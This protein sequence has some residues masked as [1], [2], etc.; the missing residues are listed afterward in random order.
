MSLPQFV[1]QIAQLDS[2]VQKARTR[3]LTEV[4]KAAASS[5]T[6]WV[7]IMEAS[8]QKASGLFQSLQAQQVQ[9]TGTAV[10][11]EGKREAQVVKSMLDAV[12]EAQTL[13]LP[14]VL[15]EV[16]EWGTSQSRN[17][18]V[19]LTGSAIEESWLE[20]ATA[21]GFRKDTAGFSH[22]A[23]LAASKMVKV[24]E[25]AQQI[26]VNLT[27]AD[28]VGVVES[29]GQE[30]EHELARLQHALLLSDMAKHVVQ[31]ANILAHNALSRATSAEASATQALDRARANT[32]RITKLKLRVQA[33]QQ[34]AEAAQFQQ[35]R[36]TQTVEAH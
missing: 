12:R 34:M 25:E 1:T 4:Q 21:E 5:L 13:K 17:Q 30:N 20:E 36:T 8:A 14:A 31:Q 32:R 15:D 9:A 35:L 19:G 29:A 28:V 27:R 24:A 11:G 33:A 6:R 16:R 23:A 7:T 26:A 2:A 3:G 10:Q 22:T 18:V